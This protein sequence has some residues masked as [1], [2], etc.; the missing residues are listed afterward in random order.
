MLYTTG[1]LTTEGNDKTPPV[2]SK[3]A[4]LDAIAGGKGLVGI[5]S[6][7]D[8]WHSGPDFF[9]DDGDQAD[10]YIKMLGGEFVRHGQQMTGRLYGSNPRFRGF[11]ECQN[12]V[13]L[14]EE[15]YALKNLAKDMHVLSWVATWTLRNTG[16][17]SVYR[18]GP[19][20]IAWARL[21]GKGRVFYTAL[22][23]REDVWE[24]PM[25]Q[26]QLVGG[27]TWSA[28]MVEAD[29]DPTITRITPH[30]ADPSPRDPPPQK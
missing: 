22:G 25:F 1:D 27:I 9:R 14:Y 29:I 20:P 5:H 23:H 26:E 3:D 24:N 17:D 13:D 2:P 18:R 21:H 12:G 8:T 7:S 6:A 16:N 28:R 30:Y 10:P 19:Y 11:A 4:F 15:W